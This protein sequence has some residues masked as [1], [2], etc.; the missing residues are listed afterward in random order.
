[1]ATVFMTDP[2]T[3]RCAL[4]DE[5][6]GGGDA[7]NPNSMRNRPLNNPKSWLANIYFH[8][9]FN[10]LEV[11]TGPT[12]VSVSHP[13]VATV[14]VPPGATINSGWA[15]AVADH[16]LLTHGLGYAPLVLVAQGSNIIW[17]GMPVQSDGVGG[18]RF[19]TVHVNTTQVKL[20]EF[21]AVGTSALAATSINYTVIVIKNPPAGSGNILFDFDPATGAVRMGKEKFNSLRRYLQ[22]VA[23]GSPFGLSYGGRTIDLA[24]GAPRAVRPDGTTFNPIL[25]SLQIALGRLGYDG[26]NYGSVFG[27]PMNY[28]GSYAGAGNIQ[29]QA[30]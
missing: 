6:P 26:F 24:N 18:M 10:Y 25:S 12:V 19:A 28:T 11:A 17:P 5:A 14:G 22:V 7:D 9:D 1:M 15:N 2:A 30:P 13:S 8:S 27:N 23:G 4:Y 21:A 20:F 3:G 16:V 29:V